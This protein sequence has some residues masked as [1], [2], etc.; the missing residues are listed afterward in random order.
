MASFSQAAHRRLS[1][2]RELPLDCPDLQPQVS[3]WA[4]APTSHPAASL[5]QLWS[6]FVVVRSFTWEN[7]LCPVLSWLLQ[8]FT[9][10][11]ISPF[12]ST[13]WLLRLER[14]LLCFI[15]LHI[16][17]KNLGLVQPLSGLSLEVY[18]DKSSSNTVFKI[19][20]TDPVLEK[21]LC[22]HHQ[23]KNIPQTNQHWHS[24]LSHT[25][26]S[27][28]RGYLGRRVCASGIAPIYTSQGLALARS[29]RRKR[30][31]IARRDIL[32]MARNVWCN[33]F[34]RR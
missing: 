3:T 15:L 30:K 22:L 13:F 24:L 20:N 14:C 4:T 9:N 23:E 28:W 8:F 12:P 33:C 26:T 19:V 10:S 25:F 32:V 29:S 6:V 17:Y 11:F 1:T 27:A 31:R 5:M 34:T 18:S 21:A 16:T 7:C 2:S